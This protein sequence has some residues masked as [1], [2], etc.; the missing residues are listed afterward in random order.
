MQRSLAL[1]L[2]AVLLV[3][4]LATGASL[5]AAAMLPAGPRGAAIALL[6]LVKAALVVLGF[7]R[8]HRENSALA[9][10]LISYA[11]LLCLLAGLRIALTG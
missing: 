7:M 5:L 4:M 9:A 1:P 6:S 10:A 8:L 11:A 3:L 2:P